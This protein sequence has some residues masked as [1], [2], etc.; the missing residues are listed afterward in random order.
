MTNKSDRSCN[1]N[2]TSVG[3]IE[4]SWPPTINTYYTIA[5][6]RKILSKRGRKY[7]KLA[8]QELLAQQ[9]ETFKGNVRVH[10]DAY[11]P[12]RRKKRD[13]DNIQK[14][15]LDVLDEHGV[16]ADDSQVF[17]LSIER[18]EPRPPGHVCIYVS[19]FQCG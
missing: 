16:Y 7:K 5:R 12:D 4:L 8:A 13:I 11:P 1:S 2:A 17:A 9:P 3:V 10:I 15:L 14:V 19:D 6:G 18:K